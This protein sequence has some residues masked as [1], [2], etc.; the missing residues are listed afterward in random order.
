LENY[1]ELLDEYNEEHG[2]NYR[3]GDKESFARQVIGNKLDG[4]GGPGFTQY[5]LFLNPRQ[6]FLGLRLELN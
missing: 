5:D 4:M 2:T 1:I 3:P 6:I